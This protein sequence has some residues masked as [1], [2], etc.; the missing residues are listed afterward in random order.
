[1]MNGGWGAMTP[2]GWV[3]MLVLWVVV[4]GGVLW[5][6]ARIFPGSS[7][8]Q[9]SGTPAAPA[10]EDPERLLERRLASGEIDAETYDQIRER[11]DAARQRKGA[12]S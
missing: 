12:W 8:A 7:Q 1:M 4:I 2:F 5:A 9:A 11:L 3:F 6:V 10:Q